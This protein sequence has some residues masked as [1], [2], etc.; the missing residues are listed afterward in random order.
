MT[1]TKVTGILNGD[2][3]LIEQYSHIHNDLKLMERLM[4]ILSDKRTKRGALD[5]NSEEAEI[6]LDESGKPIEIKRR[7]RQVSHRMIEEF[8][9]V[10]NETV[11]EYLFWAN[12]Q[13]IY[14]V[15]E[16]PD[17]D[18]MRTLGNLL[19]AFGYRIKGSEIHPNALQ[20]VLN[21]AKG[22]EEEMLV[23]RMMIRSLRKAFYSTENLK[24]FGLASDC[25][26][27]F[28]SPIRRY[29]DLVVHRQLKSLLESGLTETSDLSGIASH[30]SITERNADDAERTVDDMKKAEYM[31]EHIGE[32]YDGMVSGI[33]NYGF[34]VEL[35]NTVEGLVRLSDLSDHY[36]FNEKLL[37]LVGRRGRKTIRIGNRVRVKV[38]AADKLSGTVDFQLMEESLK[39]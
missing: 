10:C 26:C 33:T 29:P 28:T 34:Y 8:M 18:R 31:Q 2:Q 21:R 4:K 16:R 20:S 27:H 25:Y 23:N 7:E 35:P 39:R 32:K 1:Y 5:F 37:L 15:H 6:T 17:Q 3:K 24:H 30:S 22:R 14:R 13:S 38:K 12:Q 11:A 19:G 9:I 36:E